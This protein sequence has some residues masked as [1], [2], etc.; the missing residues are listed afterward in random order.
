MLGNGRAGGDGCSVAGAV[1]VFAPV[2]V[3][4]LAVGLGGGVPGGIEAVAV[5]DARAAGTGRG[6]VAAGHQRAVVHFAP[7]LLFSCSR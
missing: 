2:L 4:A 3:D 7:V 1:G 5:A 6:E